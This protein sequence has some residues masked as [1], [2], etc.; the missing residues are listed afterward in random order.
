M[1]TT[2]MTLSDRH[3]PS[4]GARGEPLH[5]QLLAG[6]EPVP[7]WRLGAGPW[8]GRGEEGRRTDDV[9]IHGAEGHLQ[10]AAEPLS[11]VV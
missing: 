2:A 11:R 10:D 1:R 7:T 3:K 9:D 6:F 8:P 5:A 4:A